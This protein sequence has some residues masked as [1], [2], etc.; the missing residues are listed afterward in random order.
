MHGMLYASL[1]GVSAC[2]SA[3]PP[4]CRLACKLAYIL[5]ESA[6]GLGQDGQRVSGA[7]LLQPMSL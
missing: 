2:L 6:T 7:A 3:F 4:G 1:D 5:V